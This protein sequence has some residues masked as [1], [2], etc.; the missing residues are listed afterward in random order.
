MP[1][2]SKAQRGY[3]WANDPKVA[4][5]FEKETP[6]GRKLPK[7]VKRKKTTRVSSG[8]ARAK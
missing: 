6:K 2:K 5:E 7:K 4:R 1:M 3:L 8:R